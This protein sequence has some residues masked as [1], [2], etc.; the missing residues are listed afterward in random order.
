[1]VW[2][3]KCICTTKNEHNEDKQKTKENNK[4]NNMI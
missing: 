3:S 1:M 4:N 2:S